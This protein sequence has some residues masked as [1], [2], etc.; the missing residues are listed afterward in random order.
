MFIAT[1]YTERCIKS[2]TAQG[3]HQ[4]LTKWCN[5]CM[6]NLSDTRRAV[7]RSIVERDGLAVASR[8]FGKPDRQINDM[9]AGR[10]AFGEKVARA[11]EAAYNPSRTPGWLDGN[12]EPPRPADAHRF[13]PPIEVPVVG[14]TQGGP[15]DRLWD[16]LCYPVGYSDEY[17][18][19]STPDQHAYALRVVGNSMAPRIMEGEWLLVEPS[20]EVY[21]G[22]DVVV[23]TVDGEVMVKRLISDRDGRLVLASINE[24]FQQITIPTSNVVFLHYVGGIHPARSA[25]QRIS[26]AEVMPDHGRRHH[27]AAVEVERRLPAHDSARAFNLDDSPRV[28]GEGKSPPREAGVST[29]KRGAVQ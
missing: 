10:K 23:K 4:A 28:T 16:E 15:P 22:D 8:K 7:L 12:V 21:P 17:L 6:S 27:Q 11:M 5:P 1:H 25:K 24:A 9:L 14:T 29:K 20:K 18:E 26:G 13:R 3:I 19:V 2:N